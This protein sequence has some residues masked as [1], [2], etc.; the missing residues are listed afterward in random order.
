[1][2]IMVSVILLFTFPTLS[3]QEQSVFKQSGAEQHPK[4]V[5]YAG[6]LP[7]TLSWQT[8]NDMG[9][10]VNNTTE[11]SHQV[12][13]EGAGGNGPAISRIALT[14][15]QLFD[16]YGIDPHGK[17]AHHTRLT[18]QLKKLFST[19][20]FEEFFLLADAVNTKTSDFLYTA[21]LDFKQSLH[22][23]AYH[24]NI[25]AIQE[26]AQRN[27]SINS[28]TIPGFT[29]LHIAALRNKTNAIRCLV[30][31]GANLQALTTTKYMPLHYAAKRGNS[32][33]LECLLD[34][35]AE[36]DAETSSGISALFLAY[37]NHKSEAFYSLV[38]RGARFSHKQHQ[39]YGTILHLA[40]NLG[41]IAAI[42]VLL[43][44]GM[45]IDIIYD[46]IGYTALHQAA[47]TGNVEVISQLVKKGANINAKTTRGATPLHLAASSAWIEAIK[48]LMRSGADKTIVDNKGFTPLFEAFAVGNSPHAQEIIDSF[49]ETNDDRN[50]I[51]TNESV[52]ATARWQLP[53][54]VY[55]LRALGA[56]IYTRDSAGKNGCDYAECIMPVI[57]RFE[58]I[59]GPNSK[60]EH[61]NTLLIEAAANGCTKIVKELLSDKRLEVNSKNNEGNT[62]L[63][64]AALEGHVDIVR[65]LLQDERCDK[66][67]KNNDGNTPFHLAV[68][69][70]RSQVVCTFLLFKTS[71]IHPANNNQRTVYWLSR[72]ASD[73]IQQLFMCHDALATQTDQFEAME[74]EVSSSKGYSDSK[75]ILIDAKNNPWLAPLLLRL[76][77]MRNPNCVG[78]GGYTVL[79]RAAELNIVAIVKQLLLREDLDLNY[80]DE[81][82]NTALHNA[83]EWGKT[84]VLDLLLADKRIDR[85]KQNKLGNT[86]LHLGFHYSGILTCFMRHNTD[87]TKPFNNNNRSVEQLI[88][89]SGYDQLALNQVFKE[90]NRLKNL[91]AEL[92]AIVRRYAEKVKMRQTRLESGLEE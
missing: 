59:C 50:L 14:K 25:G 30:Q 29:A 85:Y 83:V 73:E 53:N 72:F 66:Y 46:E 13:R 36:R 4:A 33:A 27:V 69:N 16:K 55:A 11:V 15:E 19:N 48:W 77:D 88:S 60:R 92:Q 68:L 28:C 62:A 78:N 26:L 8:I 74:C 84:D 81:N 7:E 61:G 31:L 3:M 71:T 80:Q 35:G 54:F 89:S 9:Q 52:C 21:E 10:I 51:V 38:K 75:E 43:K 32:E 57:L 86:A 91:P 70:N 40:A 45:N 42:D 39:V 37:I 79:M 87:L 6:N 22:W 20:N 41:S 23:A 47:L 67:V 12:L 63:H 5:P 76:A 90:N 44:E 64:Y 65:L 18:Q 1:M 49:I 58:D 34:L 17:I 56:D 24:D 82:G 2:K